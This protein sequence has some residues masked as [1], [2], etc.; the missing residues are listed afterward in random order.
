VPKFMLVQS[1]KLFFNQPCGL[2]KF[3]KRWSVSTHKQRRKK[4]SSGLKNELMINLYRRI[5]T[6]MAGCVAK[7][8]TTQLTTR[9]AIA[10][11]SLINARKRDRQPKHGGNWMLDGIN[12]AIQLHHLPCVSVTME[13][14][15][16]LVT[17]RRRYSRRR[18]IFCS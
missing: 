8:L 18:Q 9:L 13:V 7:Q 16:D 2:L 6:G 15:R 5:Y 10:G 11:R 4:A 3:D 17:P 12:H 14:Q 1:F